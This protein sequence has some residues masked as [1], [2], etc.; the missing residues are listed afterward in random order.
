MRTR[1]PGC[2]TIFRVTSEQLRL[3]AGKV[4]CGQCQQVFNAFDHLQSETTPGGLLPEK[5]PAEVFDPEATIVMPDIDVQLMATEHTAA[6]EVPLAHLKQIATP[7]VLRPG[8]SNLDETL[9]ASPAWG[10]SHS[11]VESTHRPS[12]QAA[13]SETRVEPALQ[14]PT[15]PEEAPETTTQAAREAGLVSVR[16]LNATPAFNRWA[17]GTLAADGVGGFEEETARPPVWLFVLIALL[18]SMALIAQLLYAY[19]TPISLRLPTLASLYALADIDV[20]LPSHVEQVAIESSELQFDNGRNLFVLQATLRN[21]A[22]YAQAWPALELTLT[23]TNDAVVARR[24]IH[25]AQY[26]PPGSAPEAFAANSEM[27]L[28]LWVDAKDMGAAGYR[29]YIFYP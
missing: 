14:V 28:R 13:V 23:D 10:E 19:R 3:K 21:R 7:A 26:L 1:C 2:D 18:L 22:P 24:V 4:R 29:L 11:P 16:E 9:V 12:A 5:A 8:A 17:A 6:I 15:I 25:A 27:A 20:P